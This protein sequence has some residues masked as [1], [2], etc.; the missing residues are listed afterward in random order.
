MGSVS[1]DNNVQW[2]LGP[3]F[4]SHVTKIVMNILLMTSH[5]FFKLFCVEAKVDRWKHTHTQRQT[6]IQADRQTERE[7]EQG[8][9]GEREKGRASERVRKRQTGRQ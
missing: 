4:Q 6:D 9:E 7:T 5:P 8:R 1:R 3:V 2:H